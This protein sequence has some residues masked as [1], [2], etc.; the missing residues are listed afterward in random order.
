M[1][2]MMIIPLNE[3]LLPHIYGKVIDAIQKKKGFLPLFFLMIGL[4]TFIQIGYSLGDWHDTYVNP[5]FQ[6]FV[7]Q[8]MLNSIFEK[9][10]NCYE[11][12]A[13]G[14]VISKFVKSPLIMIEWFTNIKDYMIPY[15]LVIIFASIYF[16][17]YDIVLGLC[18]IVTMIFVLTLLIIS[19]MQCI[20]DTL[21]QSK[22]FDDLH[23]EIDD[24]LRNLMAVYG[25]DQKSNE[26][27]N[28]YR[29]DLKYKEA[30]AATMKC[31][32]KYKAIAIPFIATFFSIFVMRCNYLIQNN[33]MKS[34]NFV[35]LFMIVLYM[36]STMMWLVDIIRNII[37]DWGMVK[38]A[39]MLLEYKPRM[40]K[41]LVGVPK[42]PSDG[43][44]LYNVSF[45]YDDSINHV[46]KNVTLYFRPGERVVL[47]GDIGSGKSTILKLLMQ[48]Y[49]PNEGDLFIDGGWYSTKGTYDIRRRI[50]YIP[51][52][53]ILFNRSIYDNLKYGSDNISNKEVDALLIRLG[54]IDEFMNLENGLDTLIGKNGSKLSGGQKQ[55]V[56]CIRILLSDPDIILMDEFT[57]AMDIKTKDLIAGILENMMVGKTI[58]MVTHD[59]YLLK[60][61]TR[62]V[63]MKDGQVVKSE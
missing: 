14:D 38:R 23:E 41:E 9:Y 53:P 3:V 16:L 30:F 26:L 58:I 22:A 45:S 12:V 50:G 63:K 27:D 59:P 19:P 28:I 36:M 8:S 43:I 46:L 13:A 25:S 57:S 44:G 54:V 24:I 33:R 31:I 29:M 52:N 42:P 55:L 11:D 61:A 21:E 7:R 10:E 51:Q 34:S 39:E 15:A 56:W 6:S 48:F 2:F 18:L 40:S 35:S 5:A 37:F 62:Q 49:I 4:V 17:Y 60:F 20:K 47:I 1:A 32:L